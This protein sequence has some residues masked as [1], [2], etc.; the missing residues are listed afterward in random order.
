MELK[1]GEKKRRVW[2][3]K[4]ERVSGRN[5]KLDC[6][7]FRRSWNS[8]T[9]TPNNHEILIDTEA[10]RWKPWINAV[11]VTWTNLVA[12]GRWTRHLKSNQAGSYCQI[13]GGDFQTDR[14]LQSSQAGS[15]TNAHWFLR[16]LHHSCFGTWAKLPPVYGSSPGATG[17]LFITNIMAPPGS[18]YGGRPNYLALIPLSMR[19][20]TGKIF[21]ADMATTRYH[22]RGKSRIYAKEK[23]LLAVLGCPRQVASSF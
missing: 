10:G 6:L 16:L 3:W 22:D 8:P 7:H 13:D 17:F 23:F 2:A 4:N 19:F 11:K 1:T 9:R 15:E 12:A 5:Q 21:C 14:W 18:P 20:P